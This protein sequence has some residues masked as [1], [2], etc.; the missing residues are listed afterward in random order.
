MMNQGALTIGFI[1]KMLYSE[2]KYKNKK[3]QVY[4]ILGARVKMI[5]LKRERKTILENYSNRVEDWRQENEQN[6]SSLVE[7][8]T[9]MHISP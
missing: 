8:E 5:N 6:R 2:Y 3:Q 4:L 7:K 1:I 9:N